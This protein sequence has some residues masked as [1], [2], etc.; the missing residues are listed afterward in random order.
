[1]RDAA[2][3]NRQGSCLFGGHVEPEIRFLIRVIIDIDG[4]NIRE[5]AVALPF[6]ELRRVHA[7][8]RQAVDGA[9]Q[10]HYTSPE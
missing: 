3:N 7:D 6:E 2:V 1:M 8:K 9:V 5:R 4:R 10:Y